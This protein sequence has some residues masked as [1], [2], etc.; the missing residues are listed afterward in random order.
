MSTHYNS[1]DGWDVK[2]L[3][4]V[5]FNNGSVIRVEMQNFLTF[6]KCEVFPGPRL[7]IVLGPMV[8]ENRLLPMQFVWHVEV[9]PKRWVDLP[10]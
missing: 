6:D 4:V 5:G 2:S 8:L 3:H 10:T 7:N 1:E 9:T